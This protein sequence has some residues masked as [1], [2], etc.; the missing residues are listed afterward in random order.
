[1]QHVFGA[2]L[3]AVLGRF[4]LLVIFQSTFTGICCFGQSISVRGKKTAVGTALTFSTFLGG[5]NEDTI[6][7]IAVDDDG[8][9]FVAGGT[10][11]IHF[12]VFAT[13]L[14]QDFHGVHD[15]YVAKL[16]SH[17][18]IEWVT[19][20]GG[21]NYDRAY[22]IE[23]DAHGFIYIAGRA[24][25]GFPT[26]DNVV[27]PMFAGDVVP[28][29][30]Y[31]QQDGFVAKLSPDGTQLI[32]STY[33]GSDGRDFIRDL[34]VDSRENVYLAV[35]DVTRPYPHVTP[36]A[37]QTAL[38][39]ASDGVVVKISADGSSVVYASYFGGSGEDGGTPSI[40]V[41][42]LGD[43][44]FLIFTK[45]DDLPVT[46]NAVQPTYGGGT[47]MG[48]AR[49]SADGSSLIYCTYFGGSGSEFS[50]THGLAIDKKDNAYLAITTQSSSLQTTAGVIQPTYGGSGG[51]GTGQ[52][53]NYTG[54][55]FLAKISSDG[56]QLLASTFLG[57]RFGEGIEGVAVNTQ[58]FVFVSG[59]T[60]SDNFPITLEAF[61][62]SNRGKADFFAVVLSDDFR[63][64]F[65]SSYIGGAED[66]FGR[67]VAMDSFG[68]FYV[69][70]MT[71]SSDWPVRNPV[72]LNFGGDFDGALCKI[73]FTGL[74]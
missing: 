71:H 11:S 2:R 54:D 57:G 1:M 5:S 64:R 31:G 22:A 14:A 33:L 42:N 50:E 12:S 60:F 18:D 28:N 47:D 27:Q 45:S 25:P 49:I 32:W 20:I 72:Q 67:A 73:S 23:L 10:A 65:Y 24:G 69:A 70:G 61:Q 7:D 74:R 41:D 6:R 46:A 4:L 40:R 13:G 51:A 19:Y 3:H 15:A 9:I 26:T 30:L 55:G 58:G 8:N 39:G 59:A 29:S 68:N 17:L 48:L 52:N 16:N 38:R 21:P 36:N 34:A 66:D 44:F 35:S 37:F 62:S 43:A 63:T 56:T 53:T